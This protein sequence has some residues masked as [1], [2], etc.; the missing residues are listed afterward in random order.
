MPRMPVEAPT[1]PPR[2]IAPLRYITLNGGIAAA[3]KNFAGN[4]IDIELI[5]TNPY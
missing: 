2:A 1:E 3:V 4:D 5:K